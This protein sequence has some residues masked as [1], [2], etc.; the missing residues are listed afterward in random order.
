MK[1]DEISRLLF[2]PRK[3]SHFA[4]KNAHRYNV[5]ENNIDEVLK[6]TIQSCQ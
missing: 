4:L 6:D 2:R 3:N 1:N 5:K